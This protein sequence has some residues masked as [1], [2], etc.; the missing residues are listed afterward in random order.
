MKTEQ[1]QWTVNEDWDISN[2][3]LKNAQL[4]LVF[5]GIDVIDNCKYYESLSVAYPQSDIVLVSTSGEI[6]GNE[7][8]ENSA[9]ATAIYFENTPIR[10]STKENTAG[11]DAE[12]IG[13]EITKDLLQDDLKHILL[14]SE[15]GHMNGD[16]L[17]AGISKNL[18]KHIAVTG[19]LAGDSARF[20]KTMMGLNNT[21]SENLVVAIGVYGNAIEVGYGSNDGWDLFGP[22]RLVTKAEE[23]VLYDLDDTNA[24][25]LYKKYLGDR[26]NEL[27]GAALLFPICILKP[28]GTKLVRTILS[29]NEENQ[30]MV[31]AGNVP[32]GSKVQFMMANFDRVIDSASNAALKSR[33]HENENPDL[34]IMVS[35]VG[36]K[37]VMQNRT[38]E[39][40]EAVAD[41]YNDEST[42][43]GFYS[44]GEIC[45]ST[46]GVNSLHNQTMTITTLKERV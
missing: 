26:A 16:H 45:P 6:H 9:S 5:A 31:F 36:R 43:C 42:F 33:I 29:I 32:V 27:P 2:I 40:I 1:L 35:C 25:E 17:V 11:K 30:S 34:T 18:P 8:F 20:S 39:E 10:I 13:M 15:G 19:G 4:V 3:Q 46:D 14:F 38:E 28:D 12:L 22:L 7:M 37:L 41:T 44:N 23:N 21:V 24:L